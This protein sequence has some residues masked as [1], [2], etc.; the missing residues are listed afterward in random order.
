MIF[1]MLWPFYVAIG[2]IVVVLFDVVFQLVISA[3]E[4]MAT[5][6]SLTNNSIPAMSDAH[7]HHQ[8]DDVPIDL[9]LL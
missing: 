7:V 8:Q 3:I 5:L 6:Q 1:L 4:I 9:L 2:T